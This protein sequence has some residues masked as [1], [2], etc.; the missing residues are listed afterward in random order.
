VE[1]LVHVSQIARHHVATPADELKE[2]Q[3]VKVKVLAVL[4][5]QKRISLSI[6][7][8]LKEEERKETEGYESPSAGL[9]LTLG[10]MYPELRNLK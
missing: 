5:E 7:E 2:G 1:G 8:A 4:P 6:K 10:D 3:E 9:G